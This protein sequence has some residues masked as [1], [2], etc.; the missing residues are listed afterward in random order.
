MPAKSQRSEVT[1]VFL[2]EALTTTVQ[3]QT[4]AGDVWLAPPAVDTPVID[5][6]ISLET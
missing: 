5:S 2:A 3:V 6:S 1:D 4:R